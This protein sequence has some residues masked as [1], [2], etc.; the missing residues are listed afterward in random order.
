MAVEGSSLGPA[1]AIKRQNAELLQS[2]VY[3]AVVLLVGAHVNAILPQLL[4]HFPYTLPPD[5]VAHHLGKLGIIQDT[6]M[7]LADE[8]VEHAD[9]PQRRRP[10]AETGPVFDFERLVKLGSQ[11]AEARSGLDNAVLTVGEAAEQLARAK[12]NSQEWYAARQVLD[13]AISQLLEASARLMRLGA[14]HAAATEPVPNPRVAGREPRFL[15]TLDEAIRTPAAEASPEAKIGRVGT[16]TRDAVTPPD[17]MRN[18]TDAERAAGRIIEDLNED[19]GLGS[20]QDPADGQGKVAPT[21]PFA[22]EASSDPRRND[23]AADTDT[24]LPV[25]TPTDSPPKVA[26][27]SPRWQSPQPEVRVRANVARGVQR[28]IDDE[29][30]DPFIRDCW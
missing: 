29:R 25:P 26:V 8:A 6:T 15:A 7:A 30:V 27:G 14:T 22:E 18:A 17:D 2:D 21:S 3:D 5:V 20:P 24:E 28:E 23:A 11:D 9:G 13:Q 1:E 12:P 10:A 16:E 4:P 19:L